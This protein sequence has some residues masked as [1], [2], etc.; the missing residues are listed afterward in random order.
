MLH[1]THDRRL[2][3]DKLTFIVFGITTDKTQSDIIHFFEKN[4]GL[5]IF[6]SIQ[7]PKQE[8]LSLIAF[9]FEDRN[10]DEI[11]V[12]CLENFKDGFAFNYTSL[13]IQSV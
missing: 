3:C 2:V 13:S 8:A 5:Q 9:E 7:H 1:A 4:F 6:Q 11:I 12:A 10:Y